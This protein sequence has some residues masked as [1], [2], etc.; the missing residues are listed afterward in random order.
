D[1]TIERHLRQPFHHVFRFQTPIESLGEWYAASP[2]VA[3]TGF[4]FHQSRSGSTL[5]GQMLSALEQ[6]IVLSE[7]LP[8]DAV[9]RAHVRNASV[10]EEQRA[11]WLRW[12]VSALAQ[13]RAGSEEHL[14]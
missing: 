12:M 8:I 11:Q 1:L 3:P 10:S 6:N 13:R 2:G 7:P 14:Y 5:V 9:L 4:I